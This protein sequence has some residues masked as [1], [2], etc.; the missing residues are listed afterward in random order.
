[1]CRIPRQTKELKKI[2]PTLFVNTTVL[3]LDSPFQIIISILLK[4]KNTHYVTSSSLNELM[5]A[6]KKKIQFVGPLLSRVGGS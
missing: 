6:L 4:A 2:S 1:M 3:E 5:S